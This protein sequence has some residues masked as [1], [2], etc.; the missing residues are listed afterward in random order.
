MR[1]S[2]RIVRLLCV[3]NARKACFV[4]PIGVLILL[5]W[6]TLASHKS[7]KAKVDPARSHPFRVTQGYGYR[8]RS[9]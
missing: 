5:T 8:G 4:I 2:K 9:L 6:S 7:I 3:F 1:L